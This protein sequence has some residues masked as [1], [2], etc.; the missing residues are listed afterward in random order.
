MVE[1]HNFAGDGWFEGAIVVYSGL[2]MSV[3]S[4]DSFSYGRYEHG[5]S[6]SVAL[7]RMKLAPARPACL[8]VD[9]V[10]LRA[11]RAVEV[12]R[13]IADMTTCATATQSVCGR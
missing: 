7:P 12:R 10:A 2:R 9:E 8:D 13:I 5:R 3:T 4:I 11:E 6:G 1:F